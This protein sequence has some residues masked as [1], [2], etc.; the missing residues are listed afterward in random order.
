MET[1]GTRRSTANS[2]GLTGPP[3]EPRWWPISVPC[4]SSQCSPQ[5]NGELFFWSA[6]SDGY[7]IWRTDGTTTGTTL[8][9]E[10]HAPFELYL[11][12]ADDSLYFNHDDGSTAASCGD[13]SLSN[14]YLN[15]GIE[16]I[17]MNATIR[18]IGMVRP[19]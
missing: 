19:F 13:W 16:E 3:A 11:T 17:T 2:G 5:L 12:A 1:A 9:A 4:T 15:G 14:P 6:G 18:T 10:I 8:A 7:D